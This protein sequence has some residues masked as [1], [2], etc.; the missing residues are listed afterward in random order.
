MFAVYGIDPKKLQLKALKCAEKVLSKKHKKTQP[1]AE[2]RQAAEQAEFQRLIEQSPT[3][4]LSPEY[5]IPA[6]A[7]TYK[8][9][10]EKAG[11]VRLT[12]MIKVPQEATDKKGRKKTVSRYVPFVAG[13]DYAKGAQA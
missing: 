2:E 3:I 1:S 6:A 11:F 7:D 5:G 10:A 13:R 4:K 9:M 8:T 12:V